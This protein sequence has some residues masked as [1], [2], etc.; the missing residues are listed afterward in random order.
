MAA[1]LGFIEFATGDILTAASANGYLASQT[2]MVFASSAA[3]SSAITSPQEG[4]F[5]YLKDTNATE[6]YSGSAWTAL[7]GG[8]G[9][10]GMTLLSTTSLTGATTTISSI[11]QTYVNLQIVIT[12]VTNAGSSGDK[13]RIAPNSSTNLSYAYQDVYDGSTVSNGGMNGDYIRTTSYNFSNS[14]TDN[15]F[16]CQIY[17]YASTTF[18]KEFLWNWGIQQSSSYYRG[19][20]SGFFASNTA[21]SSL[22]FSASGGNLST[23]TVLLYGVK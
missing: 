6:Y 10:G 15:V 1:G 17:N 16:V 9:S 14:A 23:G 22:Q 20:G 4:M 3:R 12:G 18:Y 2:V 7:G 5:S 8:G 13:I 19:V 21:I 11:D